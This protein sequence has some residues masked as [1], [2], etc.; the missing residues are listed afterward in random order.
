MHEVCEYDEGIQM[1]VPNVRFLTGNILQDYPDLADELEAELPQ[2]R[3]YLED[4][5]KTR[6]EIA[7]DVH[8]S[9]KGV[10]HYIARG[11]LFELGFSSKDLAALVFEPAKT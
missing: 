5:L 10:F 2:A 8:I 3:Q 9:D 11:K 7:V 4:H 1:N 6:E